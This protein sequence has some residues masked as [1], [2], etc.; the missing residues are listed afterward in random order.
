MTDWSVG[1]IG[2]V[3]KEGGVSLADGGVKVVVNITVVSS[4]VRSVSGGD[5]VGI[6]SAPVT[7]ALGGVASVVRDVLVGST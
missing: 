1:M 2:R 3:V 4:A 5:L 7:A 6:K